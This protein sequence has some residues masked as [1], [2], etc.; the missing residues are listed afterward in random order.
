[1]PATSAAEPA[2]ETDGLLAD[3]WREHDLSMLPEPVKVFAAGAG[4]DPLTVEWCA[5]CNAVEFAGDRYQ[6]QLA[7]RVIRNGACAEC[8]SDPERRR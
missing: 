2:P 4:V 8:W 7:E 3:L 6:R 1:V 5:F